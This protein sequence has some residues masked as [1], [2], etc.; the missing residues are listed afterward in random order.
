MS[1]LYVLHDR[2][3][4]DTYTVDVRQQLGWKIPGIY[5]YLVDIVRFFFPS[6]LLS[7]PFCSLS[8][9]RSSDPG[10]HSRL[11]PPPTHYVWCLAFLSRDDF[12]SFLP[13]RLA[14]NC[15]YHARRSQQLIVFFLFLQMNSK[16]RHGG[17]R[18]HGPTLFF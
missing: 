1:I 13:R 18:T 5:L 15:A 6:H 12:S 17:I 2:F 16:S 10:L 11:F 8:L 9:L 4:Y 3:V 7:S 14:S